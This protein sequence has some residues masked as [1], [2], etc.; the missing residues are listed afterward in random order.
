MTKFCSMTKTKFVLKDGTK[1]VFIPTSEI[2]KNIDE[3]YYNNIVESSPF[4]R[5]LGGS[6]YHEKNYTSKGYMVTKI[7]S[8]S[9]DRE[10]KSI[11]SFNFT[12]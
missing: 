10:L 3:T 5:R 2:T 7:I 8:R 12:K 4:F 9:P 11:Y 1:T 6:E